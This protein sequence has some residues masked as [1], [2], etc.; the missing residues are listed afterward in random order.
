MRERMGERLEI[1]NHLPYSIYHSLY[2][3]PSHPGPTVSENV[4][5]W[6]GQFS[7]AGQ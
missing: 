7:V 5:G 1:S 3:N 2:L 4:L 6:M